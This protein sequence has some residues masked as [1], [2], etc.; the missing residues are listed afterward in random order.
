MSGESFDPLSVKPGEKK[1]GYVKIVDNLAISFDMPVGVVYGK[2]EGP[3]L[4]VTGGLYPTEYCG[5]EAASRLYHEIEPKDLAGRFISIPVVNMPVFQFRTPWLNLRSSITPFDGGNINSQFPGNSKGRPTEILAYKLFEILSKVN[6]HVDFRGGD[7]PESHLVHTIYPRIGQKIDETAEVMAEAFGLN[8]VLP[9][10]PDI[11]HTGKGSLVY[12]L[13]IKGVASIISESGLGYNTQPSEEE[14]M[15]HVEGTKNLLKHFKM[16]Q[17]KIS[18][19]KTQNFLD[20]VWQRA[21]PTKAGVFTALVD[22]GAILKKEQ[23]IGQIKDLDGSLIEEIK[24]PV[25]GVVHTM[26]PRRVV[27]PGDGLFTI[28]KI[29]KTTGWV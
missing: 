20:M 7:L 29:D 24:S 6:Y 13:A 17:G 21:A 18:K 1:F 28:L 11:G 15:P 25:N 16:M 8:Y 19:P 23:I 5:V 9:G 27:Y 12:E 2:K 10:T 3:T 26:Y 22:Q 14:I 4:A